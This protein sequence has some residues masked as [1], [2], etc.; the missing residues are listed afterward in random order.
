MNIPGFS[1]HASLYRTSNRYHA[2]VA[3]LSS[4]IADQSV[5][6]AYLPGPRT[7]ERCRG[8]TEP[9]AGLRDACLSVVASRVAAAC[10]GSLGWGCGAAIAWGYAEAGGCYA[11]YATCFGL[12]QIPSNPLWDGPCCPKVCGIHIPGVAGSGCCDEGE[13]CVGS[14]NPNTR[15]GCCPVG[16]ECHGN[17]CA[18]GEHCLEGGVC[19]TEPGYFEPSYPPRP[20][21]NCI[22]GGEPCGTKCCP[23][24]TVCCGVRSDGQPDCKV[25][26]S[27]NACLG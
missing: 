13:S 12:C 6:A 24:G 2:S 17:C 4:S 5:V 21:N 10:W 7:Q 15:N 27:T 22:F 26:S 14:H 23:V 19:S 3:E 18:K 25:G 8:C 1:A 16:Q 9:C 20:V 11:H